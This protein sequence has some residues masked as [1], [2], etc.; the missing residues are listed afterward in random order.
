MG[1]SFGGLSGGGKSPVY[2]EQLK[3][4]FVLWALQGSA[5]LFVKFLRL[6]PI[7]SLQDFTGSEELVY[8]VWT[9]A[10]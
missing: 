6:L 9:P 10:G 5:P 4:L 3:N 2:V 8:K 1:K 7:K